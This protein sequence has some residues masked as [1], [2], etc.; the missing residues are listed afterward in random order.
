MGL[1]RPA[2]LYNAAYHLEPQQRGGLNSDIAS[3]LETERD[4]D[5]RNHGHRSLVL[6]HSAF[7]LLDDSSRDRVAAQDE[8]LPRGYAV[9]E[10][11]RNFAGRYRCGRVGIIGTSY[12][13][14][15]CSTRIIIIHTCTVDAVCGEYT[16]GRV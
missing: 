12:P 1:E 5:R 3:T 15:L 16:S 2:F 14:F 4:H 9:R 13:L 11:F 10:R 8:C 6:Y 7:I